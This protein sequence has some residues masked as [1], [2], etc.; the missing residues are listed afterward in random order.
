MAARVALGQEGWREVQVDAEKHRA[1]ARMAKSWRRRRAGRFTPSAS[2]YR[3]R[4]TAVSLSNV[5]HDRRQDETPTVPDHSS[6]RKSSYDA[7]L[8][9]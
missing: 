8:L 5:Q 2:G 7:W 4:R 3:R 1:K 9:G 6:R